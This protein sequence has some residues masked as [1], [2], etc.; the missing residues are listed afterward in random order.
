MRIEMKR[1][2]EVR[3]HPVWSVNIGHA[4]VVLRQL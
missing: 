2:E 1:E 4:D 3:H